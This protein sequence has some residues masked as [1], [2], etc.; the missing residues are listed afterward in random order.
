M[1]IKSTIF[2]LLSLGVSSLA[3]ASFEGT[4]PHRIYLGP[5]LVN[6]QLDTHVHNIHVKGSRLFAG[7]R[8]GYEYLKPC[9]LYFGIDLFDSGCG[10]DF[11]ASRNGKP[12]GGLVAWNKASRQFGSFEL[13]GGYNYLS[14]ACANHPFLLT[15][16]VGAGFYYISSV[17]HYHTQGFHEVLPYVAA[18]LHLKYALC[19]ALDVGVNA[20]V[21]HSFAAERWFKGSTATG[22]LK[23]LS[24]KFSTWGGEVSIPLTWHLD[25]AHR[26]EFQA[27][28]YAL[29]IKDTAYGLRLLFGYRF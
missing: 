17:D 23:T 25:C 14:C 27:E 20:K 24:E 2:S 13:R 7:S 6:L 16:F 29:K 21:L 15:P 3:C 4:C 18:G 19:Q 10:H 22:S 9:R 28:P 11:S 1:K 26:W 5:E 12:A 8:I